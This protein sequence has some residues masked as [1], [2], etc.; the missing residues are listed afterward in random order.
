MSVDRKAGWFDYVRQLHE[1][2][3]GIMNEADEM[4][5]GADVRGPEVLAMALPCRTLNDAV[6]RSG[7]KLVVNKLQ[8]G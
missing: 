5:V 2:G 1:A 7:T 8:T 3:V 6:A 4:T